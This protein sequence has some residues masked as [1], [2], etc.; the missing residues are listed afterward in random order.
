TLDG[1]SG[2]QRLQER[3]LLSAASS[4]ADVNGSCPLPRTSSDRRI[5][6]AR[7]RVDIASSPVAMNVGHMIGSSLRQPPQP[8]HCSRLP[9][10][11]WSLKAKASRGSNGRSISIVKLLRSRVLIFEANPKIITRLKIIL[12]LNIGY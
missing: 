12:E 6:F 11:D 3:Q 4:S 1:Q 7:P 9:M 8:L 5:M 2:V 10:N